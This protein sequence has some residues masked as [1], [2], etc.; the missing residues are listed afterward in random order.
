MKKLKTAILSLA[1]A[2]LPFSGMAQGVQQPSSIPAQQTQQPRQAQQPQ[3]VQQ[4]QQ[5][6]QG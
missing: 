2:I 6:Q 3:Q 5:G 4:P 1:I